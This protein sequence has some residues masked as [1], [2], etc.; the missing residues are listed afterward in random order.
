MKLDCFISEFNRTP[1]RIAWA[2]EQLDFLLKVPELQ[3]TAIDAGSTPEE[4]AYLKERV[5]VIEQPL[6]GS[7]HRRFLIAELFAR[8]PIYIFADN[9]CIPKTSNWL[10]KA[11]DVMDSHPQFG[12]AGLRMET[13]DPSHDHNFYDEEI[14]SV[15]WYI[16]FSFIHK[17]ARDPAKGKFR[18]PLIFDPLNP[19]DRQYCAAV[20]KSGKLTGV[21]NKIYMTNLGNS[22]SSAWW[23]TGN[24]QTSVADLDMDVLRDT[25]YA[26]K[27]EQ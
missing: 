7:I 21:F 17:D 6:D 5:K 13:C 24:H 19:D 15:A 16:A 9:D 22:E 25:G 26:V 3:I 1:N 27:K 12:M 2:H 11:L 23:Q 14:R 18:V 20:Q 10:A 4:L 8:S